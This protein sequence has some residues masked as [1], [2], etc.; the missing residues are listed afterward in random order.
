VT[1]ATTGAVNGNA[2]SGLN[3]ISGNVTTEGAN[4]VLA[5][6]SSINGS[7]I[8]DI[9]VSNIAATGTANSGTFLRGDGAWQTPNVGITSVSGQ[10]SVFYVSGDSIVPTDANADRIVFFDETDNGIKYLA[11]GNS[12]AITD[13]TIDAVFGTASGTVCQGN[14]SRLSDSRTPTSHTHGNITNAGAI[15]STSGLPIKTGTSGVLEAGAFGT[16]A[17]QFSEGNHVHGNVTSAGAIGT[18]ANRPIKTG[19][20]GVL[21]AGSAM[22]GS[23]GL[24]IDGAG[25]AITTG[26]KGYLRVPYACTINSVEIVADQSGSIVIDVWR[27]T[28]ANFP[29]TVGDTIVASAKP[30]LSSAQ[31]N[32]DTTLTG[33]TT[34]LSEGDY[35]AFNVDSATTVTRVALTIK[36]TRTL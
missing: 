5:E 18:T 13:T 11:P 12:L 16:G 32:Q 27:D 10:I 29:P 17:G 34:S 30:T 1:L 7:S 14:D 28:Y 22:L 3:G 33:W 6:I 4:A 35:L 9:E 19:T 26:V 23:L 21:E 8:E 36:A 2:F 31:K 20:S 25:S 24:V 15:G